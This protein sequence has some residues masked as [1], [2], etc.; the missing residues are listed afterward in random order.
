MMCG[1]FTWPR[2]MTV[3]LSSC[4]PSRFHSAQA[5][6]TWAP[7]I[8]S[9]HAWRL[10]AAVA[11]ADLEQLKIVFSDVDGAL[12]HYPNGED[13]DDSCVDPANRILTLPPSATGMTGVISSLTLQSCRALRKTGVKLVLVS[14]MR[15]STLLNRLP[16]L[17]KADA[18]CSEA[19]GRI[20]YP[21]EPAPG[22]VEGDSDFQQQWTPVEFSGASSED[23][24]P[25]GLREDRAWRKRVGS[26]QGAGKDGYAGNEISSDR[27]CDADDEEE[28]C[29]I[30]YDNTA[31]FPKQEEVIP[32]PRRTGALW[33]FA[34]R[35][36]DDHG[37]VLDT[38]SYSTCFRVNRK[39][40]TGGPKG[41]EN[42]R[43]LLEGDI[44]VP[45][46]LAIST[47]LG[48]IDVYPA[49]SGKRNCCQFLADSLRHDMAKESVCICDDDND[50]EMA[51]ACAHA[52]IPALT[53]ESMVRCIRANPRQFTQ[54]VQE[55]V[56]E[57][58][59]ATEAA[60]RSI[61]TFQY[62]QTRRMN[63][64]NDRPT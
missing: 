28:E 61:R 50:L 48:C 38:K 3:I 14:G 35:L 62:Q 6:L 29:L 17:P 12:I 31:G 7:P 24:R 63:I 21:T 27:L 54:T 52:Y 20:F 55:G 56:V 57:G 36:Q 10:G 41:E 19:G 34:R 64:L 43:A 1:R 8:R 22:E 15:T 18:Y 4:L 47:N 53:S 9:S 49:S 16:Y 42:F 26:A 33:D 37:L 23:L 39:H 25:F 46:Q 58:T 59:L 5:F 30:D 60:L 11:A 2:A 44:V 51:L 32:V 45:P 13:E 40:Q